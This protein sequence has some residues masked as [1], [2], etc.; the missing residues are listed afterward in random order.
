MNNIKQKFMGRF[1]IPYGVVYD[2]DEGEFVAQFS[3]AS[4]EAFLYQKMF[5]AFQAGADCLG[6]NE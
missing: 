3:W 1:S 5:E 6:D 4:S 2:L